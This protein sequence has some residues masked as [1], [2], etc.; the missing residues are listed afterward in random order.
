VAATPRL[1]E[2]HVTKLAMALHKAV[3]MMAQDTRIKPYSQL[4]PALPVA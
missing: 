1:I 2:S 3:R 4:A